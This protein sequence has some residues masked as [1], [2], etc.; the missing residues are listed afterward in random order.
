MNQ[1]GLENLI[2]AAFGAICFGIGYLTAFIV[3]RNCWRDQ[4]IE[5]GD[6]RYN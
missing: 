3:M 5:R 6:A 1:L 4:M 2:V